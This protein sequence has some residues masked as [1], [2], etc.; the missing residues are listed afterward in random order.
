MKRIK[1]PQDVALIAKNLRLSFCHVTDIQPEILNAWDP[2]YVCLLTGTA[3]RARFSSIDELPFDAA[4][5]HNKQ[6][7]ELAWNTVTFAAIKNWIRSDH[8]D[9]KCF[10]RAKFGMKQSCP[11]CNFQTCQLC[12]FKLT[13]TDKMISG[14]HL[15]Q[16]GL[17]P[18]Q[19]PQCKVTSFSSDCTA[20]YFLFLDEFESL[21]EHQQYFLMMC[22]MMDPHSEKRIQTWTE[23][24]RMKEGSRVQICGLRN[25][26]DL[27]GEFG[28]IQGDRT[29][30]NRIIRWPVRLE[31]DPMMCVG[32]PLSI[33]E[34]N[35]IL[36]ADINA[37]PALLDF[38]SD[39]V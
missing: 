14:L 10:E 21:T 22:Q 6:S 17:A 39:K 30:K 1:S 29:E 2:G 20:L 8:R 34:E 28:E 13:C 12:R 31:D 15:N 18:Y 5:Y 26:E 4:I 3:L 32:K 7:C 25:R 37:V 9:S 16:D 38:L 19:C 27:N 33:K 24:K 11:D 35:L 36:Q 23:M